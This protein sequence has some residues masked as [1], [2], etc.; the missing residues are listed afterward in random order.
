MSSLLYYS[1]SSNLT[2]DKIIEID[3]YVTKNREFVRNLA[4][5][6]KNKTRKGIFV[7]FFVT[8]FFPPS[9]KAFPSIVF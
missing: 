3:L 6:A 7:I 2:K 9:F 5:N 1:I 8:C 4:S